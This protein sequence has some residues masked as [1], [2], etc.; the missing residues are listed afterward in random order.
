MF[1]PKNSN[2][3][4]DQLVVTDAEQVSYRL[5]AEDGAI[6]IEREVHDKQAVS[7]RLFLTAHSPDELSDLIL[8]DETFGDARRHLA[9]RLVRAGAGHLSSAPR[10]Q[11]PTD[12]FD[13]LALLTPGA[14]QATVV[15]AL[16]AIGSLCALP[17]FLAVW[18]GR[19]GEKGHISTRLLAGCSPVWARTMVFKRWCVTDPL[20]SH[21]RVR[22]E[23]VGNWQ[24][25]R[26]SPGQEAAARMA[27]E[28]GFANSV[29]VPVHE[30]GGRA[31]LALIYGASQRPDEHRLERQI[32][33]LLQMTALR[34]LT[35]ARQRRW[36]EQH[37]DLVLTEVQ[38]SILLLLAQDFTTMDVANALNQPE[39]RITYHVKRLRAQFNAHSG[40]EVALRAMEAGLIEPLSLE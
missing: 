16:Q 37:G 7:H 33:P 36:R 1:A 30:A 8:H 3:V 38:R 20:L 27:A 28:H 9:T 34:L 2:F 14:S 26:L 21:A 39:G 29:C 24:M 11:L 40:L 4:D 18:L 5:A 15:A 31:T 32:V 12:P 35:W 10:P 25:A 6:V 23:V 17:V 22:N 19:H 13:L